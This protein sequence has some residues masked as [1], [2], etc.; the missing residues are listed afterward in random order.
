AADVEH[1]AEAVPEQFLVGGVRL[2]APPGDLQRQRAAVGGAQ[3]QPL[4]PA[5]QRLLVQGDRPG[6]PAG[7]PV[8][9]AV[10]PG[11]PAPRPLAVRST[12][13]SS[14]AGAAKRLRGAWRA[15]ATASAAVSTSRSGGRSVIRSPAPSIRA[16]W[17][18]PVLAVD[19]GTPRTRAGSGLRK[20]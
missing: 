12:V 4:V 18:E 9:A 16:R 3:H 20:P 17:I 11:E 14:R 2:R 19:M 7:S 6:H 10:A 15:T 1:R 13:A 8:S 5:A